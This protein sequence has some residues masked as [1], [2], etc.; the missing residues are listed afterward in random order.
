MHFYYSFYI[1]TTISFYVYIHI[2]FA[3]N[4][5]MKRCN[6]LFIQGDPS[7]LVK[8]MPKQLSDMKKAIQY[9]C[10]DH[11]R[12]KKKSLIS[13]RMMKKLDSHLNYFIYFHYLVIYQDEIDWIAPS[14]VSKYSF[15]SMPP[16]YPTIFPLLPITR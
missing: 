2:I 8:H 7:S 16:P 3:F 13:H 15:F 4:I 10:I 5:I 1:F 11:K 9:C 14:N 12:N 6:H